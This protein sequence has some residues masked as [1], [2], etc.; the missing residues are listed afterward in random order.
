MNREQAEELL[1]RALDGEVT[2]AEAE[3][4]ARYRREH[5]E[6][7]ELEAAWREAGRLLSEPVVPPVTPEA[8]WHDVQRRLRLARAEREAR[9]PVFGWRLGWAASIIAAMLLLVSAVAFLQLRRG[10]APALAQAPEEGTRVE[11]VESDLP[12]AAPMV[13]EDAE[14]GWVV[15]WVAG[16]EDEIRDSRF[17]I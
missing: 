12:G 16:I 2:S 17:E 13:Y 15:I 11:F 4:L 10:V 8:A 3:N 14:S 7:D 6:L 5:P 9:S 1:S